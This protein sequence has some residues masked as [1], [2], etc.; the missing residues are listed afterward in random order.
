LLHQWR[1]SCERREFEYRG[2]EDDVDHRL[3]SRSSRHLKIRADTFFRVDPFGAACGTHIFWAGFVALPP[4]CP[5][6]RSR[7]RFRA[8]RGI[9]YT[10]A[11]A[12]VDIALG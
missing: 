5:A 4:E 1:V 8:H 11:S 12:P 9:R 10:L 6:R 2:D 3:T 7:V